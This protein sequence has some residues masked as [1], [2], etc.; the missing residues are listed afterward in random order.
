M[1]EWLKSIGGVALFMIIWDLLRIPIQ[2]WVTKKFLQKDL[3]DIDKAIDG[4]EE[5]I[6]EDGHDTTTS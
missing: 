5:A 2:S 4:V 3:D 1:P 6:E